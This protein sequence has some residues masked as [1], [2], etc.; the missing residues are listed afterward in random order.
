M[1]Q[2]VLPVG[3]EACD[4]RHM[5]LLVLPTSVTIAPSSKNGPIRSARRCIVSTGLQIIT[6]WEPVTAFSGVSC[7]SLH[8]PRSINS[9]RTSGRL[10][11]I[12][13]DLA[14]LRLPIARAKDV[15]S[16]PGAKMVICLI[17]I[18]TVENKRDAKD[19]VKQI[20][21]SALFIFTG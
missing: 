4:F 21:R 13:T 10:A 19:N 15:P 6:I 9:N 7:T 11:Q 16:N 2:S 5:R 18:K 8:Q 3:N 17:T 20:C 12:T 14:R 1:K